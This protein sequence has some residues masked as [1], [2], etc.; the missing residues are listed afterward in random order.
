MIFDY[1]KNKYLTFLLNYQKLGLICNRLRSFNIF[2]LNKLLWSN[3]FSVFDISLGPTQI[4]PQ[5]YN[6]IGI[7]FSLSLSL[8]HTQT[9]TL[10]LSLSLYPRFFGVGFLSLPGG[11]SFTLFWSLIKCGFV[12]ST[13][14]KILTILLA[15]PFRHRNNNRSNKIVELS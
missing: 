1:I 2:T 12:T 11:L 9:H 7:W 3:I 6:S 5:F 10:S 4:K 13:K 14:R 15:N 8:T